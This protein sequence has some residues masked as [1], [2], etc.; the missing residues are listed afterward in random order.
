MFRVLSIG[1]FWILALGCTCSLVS[2]VGIGMFCVGWLCFV[3]FWYVWCVVWCHVGF[4]L[5]FQF[6]V[7][8]EF[9]FEF[10]LER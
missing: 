5:S 8:F 6:L 2:S 9:G 10:H 4:V 7:S 3:V 1:V